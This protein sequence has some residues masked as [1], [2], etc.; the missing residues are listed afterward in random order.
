MSRTCEIDDANLERIFENLNEENRRNAIFKAITKGGQELVKDTR[1][2]LIRVLPNA[3]RGQ[4]FG[5]PMSKGVKL[6]KDKAYDEVKVHIMGDFRL[7]FFE[8]GTDDR[9]LKKPLPSS[10]STS[11]YK[12]RNGS[13]TPGGKPYRGKIIGKHFFQKAREDSDIENTITSALEKEINKL[14]G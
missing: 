10:Y 12:F 11:K 5:T 9:Y 13:T 14:L 4:K 6:V 8:M 1:D 7:K 2:E 3:N